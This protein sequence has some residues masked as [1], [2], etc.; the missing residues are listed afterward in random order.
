[1]ENY[2]AFVINLS[3]NRFVITENRGKTMNIN[4]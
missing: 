4:E 1:M 2:P 3:Q